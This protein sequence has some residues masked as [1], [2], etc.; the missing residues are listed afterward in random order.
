MMALFDEPPRISFALPEVVD[1]SRVGLLLG[2][3]VHDG[4]LEG[5]TVLEDGRISLCKA[6]LFTIDWRYDHETD[7]WKDQNAQPDQQE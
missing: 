5:V 1:G 3:I 4:L 2:L 7:R 6:G